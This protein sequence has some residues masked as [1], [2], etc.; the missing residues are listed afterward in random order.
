VRELTANALHASAALAP[1]APT[2]GAV[3]LVLGI[4]DLDK[5][6]TVL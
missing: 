4:D 1:H 5:G 3:R 2:F 6:R